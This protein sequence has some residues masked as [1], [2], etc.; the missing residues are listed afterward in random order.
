MRSLPK[1]V[2]A[3]NWLTLQGIILLLVVAYFG[4]PLLVPMSYG[5]LVAIVLYPVCRKLEIRGWPRNLAIGVSLGGVI[6]LFLALLALLALQLNVFL[7]DLPD[8][9]DKLTPAL[10]DLRKAIGT[11]LHLTTDQQESWWQ[12]SIAGA[13]GNIV[14]LAGNSVSATTTTIISFF[15][16]P[17]YA[18]LFLY[19]R[20][21]FL[22]FLKSIAGES[23]KDQLPQLLNEVIHTYYGFIKGMIK[24]YV[25]VGI[26]NSIGLLALGIPHAILFGMLTAIMTIIP[27]VGIIVSA[28]LPISVAWLTKDS[29]WY[30][31]GVIAI[32]AVVQYLEAN[33]IF[34]KVVAAQLN[35]STWATLVAIVAGGLLWG[36]SGMILFIPFLAIL[37]L[38]VNRVNEWEAINILL[39]RTT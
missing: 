1:L 7:K 34:P 5:L 33:L 28:L 21:T 30:P 26:L 38:V 19:N 9:L 16:I 24:V 11:R 39:S 36:I 4:K 27:Y 12:Q 3:N 29:V 25:I 22:A 8:L 14:R 15:L 2:T 10:Q 17:V 31:I 20:S 35:V 13:Q 32:F 18:A 6:V 23:Y 37:K